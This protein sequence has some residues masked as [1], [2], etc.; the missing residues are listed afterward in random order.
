MSLITQL[1]AFAARLGQEDKAIH[2]ALASKAAAGHTHAFGD[3]TGKPTTLAGYGIT[4]AGGG[5]EIDQ[6][7][8]DLGDL[9]T[10]F[11]AAYE[12]ELA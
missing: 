4:D 11:V 3:I 9:S 1:L 10:D 5:A 8:L 6:L 2:T 7:L 12:A